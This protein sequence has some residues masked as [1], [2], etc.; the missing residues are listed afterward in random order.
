MSLIRG[1]QVA[2]P[3]LI[4]AGAIVA[5]IAPEYDVKRAAS[6]LDTYVTKCVN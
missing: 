5:S 4:F 1:W 3:S 2:R 6:S